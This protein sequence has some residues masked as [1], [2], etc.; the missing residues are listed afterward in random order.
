MVIDGHAGAVC[1][2]A[3]TLTTTNCNLVLPIELTSFTVKKYQYENILNWVTASERDNDYFTIERSIDGYY[4]EQISKL[5]GAGTSS[6]QIKYSYVDDSFKSFINYYRL[7]QTD[8]NSDFKYSE[9]L[10]VDN[11]KI[12]KKIVKIYNTM[13]Q[14]VN[15][16]YNGLKIIFFDDSTIIKQY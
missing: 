6:K 7:K 8:Y 16:D 13:G 14:E 3:V 9:I 10:V 15:L 12:Y 1:N 5:N 4:W 11:R 2:F